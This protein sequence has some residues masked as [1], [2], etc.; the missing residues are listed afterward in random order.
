MTSFMAGIFDAIKAVLDGET[1]IT[2]LVPVANIRPAED[3]LPPVA[4][5]VIFFAF[6]GGNHNRRAKRAIA[7]IT[8]SVGS[9]D[10]NIGAD[11][12]L[13]LVREVLTPKKLT[14]IA[15][16]VVVHQFR[17]D[18]AFTD[19]GTTGSDRFLASTTFTARYVQA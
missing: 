4:G 2:D 9:E 18:D 3:P 1:A 15:A 14:A 19:S 8:I 7:S 16:G 6:T 17:E 5:A 13:D 10:N 12:I 11:R